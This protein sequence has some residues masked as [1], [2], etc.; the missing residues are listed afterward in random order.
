VIIAV[1]AFVLLSGGDDDEDPDDTTT[2]SSATTAP[3]TTSTTSTTTST[4]TTTTTTAPPAT[5]VAPTA[6][7]LAPGDPCSPEEGSPDCIDPEGDG[8]Y[9]YL[10]GGA[11]CLAE[12]P[13]GPAICSD[14][15]GDGRAGYP[16]S[17]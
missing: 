5:T 14:L 2:T 3:T 12:N 4:T 16:D 13:G 11:Q 8:S 9:T 17:G 1:L 10:I 15:D 6:N 7:A